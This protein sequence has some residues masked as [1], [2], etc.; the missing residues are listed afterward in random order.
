MFVSPTVDLAAFLKSLLFPST[1]YTSKVPICPRS[2][3][4]LSVDPLFRA[5]FPLKYVSHT[6]DIYVLISESDYFFIT[7][8]FSVG[9]TYPNKI[10]S[11]NTCVKRSAKYR[12]N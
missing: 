4:S 12:S 8:N 11:G 2:A 7:C 3:I 1:P 9:T 5:P 10:S 6:P